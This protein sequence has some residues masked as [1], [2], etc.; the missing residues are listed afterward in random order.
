MLLKNTIFVAFLFFHLDSLVIFALLMLNP[1]SSALDNIAPRFF[2]PSGFTIA[3][4][5]SE[6]R[7]TASLENHREK[8]AHVYSFVLSRIISIMN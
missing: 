6:E 8:I 4:V 1:S 3:R 2:I 5:D 7:D